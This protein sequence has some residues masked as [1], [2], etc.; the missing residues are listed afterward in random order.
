[1]ACCVFYILLQM[2]VEHKKLQEIHGIHTIEYDCDV[3]ISAL[4]ALD[5]TG[6]E[7]HD[8]VL[9]SNDIT[10]AD[11]AKTREQGFGRM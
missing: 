9:V 4:H 8:P 3:V 5:A 7:G 6:L 10:N 1:M 2:Q 11:V